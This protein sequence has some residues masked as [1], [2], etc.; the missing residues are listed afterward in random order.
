MPYD[1]ARFKQLLN[2]YYSGN[3][4]SVEFDEFWQ[5][6]QEQEAEKFFQESL[7]KLWDETHAATSRIPRTE[8]DARMK[9]LKDRLE[10]ASPSQSAPRKIVSLPRLKWAAA[11]IA[12]ISLV[13]T[14][15]YFL[16]LKRSTPSNSLSQ[17]ATPTRSI[18]DPQPG[19]NRAMLTLADG[20]QIPL[21][22]S[23]NGLLAIQGKTTITKQKDGQIAYAAGAAHSA[24]LVYNVLST[25]RGGQYK[26][27]LPDGTKVWL[28]AS[29]TLKY[30]VVFVGDQ[31]KVEVTG[32]AYFE[33]AKD[34]SKPFIVTADHVRVEVLGTHFN[35]NNYSDEENVKA[36][37]LEGSI[38]L[39]ASSGTRMIKPGEQ[40][41]ANAEGGIKIE[42]YVDTE[43]IIAWKEG[44][45]QFDDENIKSIMRQLARWYDVDV[46]F[47]G[48]VNKH[49]G[50]VISRNVPLSKV[51]DML[52][53]AG[54]VKLTISG[55]KVIVEEP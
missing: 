54:G 12:F 48:T 30:P 52:E 55:K 37:L 23:Q 53:M 10:S 20:R 22:D 24:E 26:I 9:L 27:T 46:E 33:V 39:H 47:K 7:P 25:P 32:E 17:H 45:F 18:V 41:Q 34:A 36:T 35:V 40:A 1:Q 21:D 50:G 8:W 14:S 44:N 11:I 6:A 5:L 42:N 28:N 3:L 4:N 49:F 13:S 19:D 29:T 38:R 15:Y 51:L 31:R 2:A 16:G 43:E